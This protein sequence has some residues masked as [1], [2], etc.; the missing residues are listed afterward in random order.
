MK[1]YRDYQND[2]TNSFHDQRFKHRHRNPAVFGFIIVIIGL[3]LLARQFGLILWHI[4]M[5]PFLLIALGLFIGI[6]NK[7]SN[8]AP[9]IL[10]AVG[11]FNL[12]PRFEIGG[13]DSSDLAVP[14]LLVVAGLAIIFRPR[15]KNCSSDRITTSTDTDDTLNI[16]VTFG[17]RK[18]IVTSKQFKGGNISVA[19]AGAE[20]NLMQADFT[21]T[22]ILDLKVSFGG[23]EIVVPSHWEVQMDVHPSFGHVE[24]NRVIRTPISGEERKLLILKGSCSF[25]NIELK[26]Y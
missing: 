20:I 24:D 15:K 8:N 6:R 1:E 14:L 26:S 16:D 11:I 3:A 19:F 25:G 13:V 5:W 10:I 22:P 23:I 9:Y 4:H 18:A 17:G 7:F 2:P 12:I 21:D